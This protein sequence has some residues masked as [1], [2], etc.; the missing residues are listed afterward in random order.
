MEPFLY[1]FHYDFFSFGSSWALVP[2]QGNVGYLECGATLLTF[3]P[4]HTQ[5]RSL[6]PSNTGHQV[7]SGGDRL[8]TVSKARCEWSLVLTSL[9]S[10]FLVALEFLIIKERKVNFKNT[11]NQTYWTRS[12]LSRWERCHTDR[13]LYSE[14]KVLLSIYWSG[15]LLYYIW[16]LKREFYPLT[17]SSFFVGLLL[18][19]LN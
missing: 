19:N 4:Q 7:V 18:W 5:G 16:Q 13:C 1:K 6:L 17:T 9:I 3:S 8:L 2:F 14:A 15:I 12:L 10:H 11:L